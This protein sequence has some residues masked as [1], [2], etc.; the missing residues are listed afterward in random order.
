MNAQV[1]IVNYR[2]PTLTARTI[3]SI[4]ANCRSMHI[5]VVDNS[6]DNS[7]WQSL[8]NSLS[9]VGHSQNS[10]YFQK[11]D[12][13]IELLRAPR[14]L[15]FGGGCN[16]GVFNSSFSSRYLWFVNSD[17]YITED[18]FEPLARVLELP[19]Y[20]MVSSL[21]YD[22]HVKS[23]IVIQPNL[24]VAGVRDFLG[25]FRNTSKINTL[26]DPDRGIISSDYIYGA[27][28]AVKTKD[29]LECCGFDENY[30]MYLEETDLALRA[31][32][33]T[34]KK[35]CFVNKSS[36]FHVGGA[37]DVSNHD[38]KFLILKNYK[39]FVRK[40]YFGHL[41]IMGN[42]WC[43]LKLVNLLMSRLVYKTRQKDTGVHTSIF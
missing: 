40:N 18:A 1:V 37:S 20:V 15:G 29:F 31:M 42:V 5:T 17:C 16:F 23:E 27:S 7:E 10:I 4:C 35:C 13:Q 3:E 19:N 9:Q 26:I 30:F 24:Q 6:A 36:V 22:T 25:Y 33:L 8:C 32:R 28:F 43:F 38:K 39:Y 34:G 11:G 41:R 12:C 2:T 14:N 21:V